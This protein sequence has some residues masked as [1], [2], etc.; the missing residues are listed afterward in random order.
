MLNKDELGATALA[1]C[2]GIRGCACAYSCCP[3]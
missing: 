1:R 2:S 3:R